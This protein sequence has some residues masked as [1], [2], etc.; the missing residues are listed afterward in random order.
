MSLFTPKAW[1]F[2]KEFSEILHSFQSIV[3]TRLF[4]G[5]SLL[6]K[7]VRIETNKEA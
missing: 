6:M 7:K 3:K 1:K 4:L 2:L 5:L